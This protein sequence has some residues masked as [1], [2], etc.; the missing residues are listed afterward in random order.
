MGHKKDRN[1]QIH[2]AS[3]SSKPFSSG[4]RALVY[5]LPWDR[6]ALFLNAIV[7]SYTF[8]KQKLKLK[9]ARRKVGRELPYT[10]VELEFIL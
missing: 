4:R 5:D 3:V 1:T 10:N 8:A 9:L 2:L 6:N 7:S